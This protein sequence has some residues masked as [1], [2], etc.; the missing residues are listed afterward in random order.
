MTRP[1]AAPLATLCTAVLLAGG[2]GQAGNHLAAPGARGADEGEGEARGR[3]VVAAER[4]DGRPKTQTRAQ[5]P[6]A[7]SVDFRWASQAA[8]IPLTDLSVGSHGHHRGIPHGASGLTRAGPG[9]L[10]MI[11]DR[12]LDAQR[13]LHFTDID[14]SGQKPRIGRGATVIA[15]HGDQGCT[16]N[17][18]AVD[19]SPDG[20]LWVASDV[21]LLGQGRIKRDAQGQPLQA[22]VDCSEPVPPGWFPRSCDLELNNGFETLTM[23]GER[24]LVVTEKC[25]MNVAEGCAC[26]GPRAHHRLFEVHWPEL[27]PK[28]ELHVS[29][30]GGEALRLTAA[31]SCPGRLLWLG[32]YR[33]TERAWHTVLLSLWLEDDKPAA[34]WV[35]ALDNQ[36]FG[37]MPTMTPNLEGLAVD[38]SCRIGLVVNDDSSSNRQ[39]APH[40]LLRS[41]MLPERPVDDAESTGAP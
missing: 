30:P 20:T 36:A 1:R 32:A 10:L 29:G 39:V 34:A 9:Q 33:D 31:A 6:A 7:W 11:S 24:P 5:A 12:P 38:P 3:T 17:L 40:P 25:I 8:A 41:F 23:F 27:R 15:L 26:D 35:F 2:C 22:V 37:R 4:T 18:E 14:W 16:H 28:G 21:G 19:L 13:R